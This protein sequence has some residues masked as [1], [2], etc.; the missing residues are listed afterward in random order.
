MVTIKRPWPK[1]DVEA[2]SVA[3]GV[4]GKGLAGQP[5]VS[6]VGAYGMST[7]YRLSYG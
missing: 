5:V 2:N 1:A 7:V 4:K 6:G 3:M